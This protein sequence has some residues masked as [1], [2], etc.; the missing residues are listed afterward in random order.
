MFLQYNTNG[1][2]MIRAQQ[3]EGSQHHHEEAH[4]MLAALKRV[5]R[6]GNNQ[7]KVPKNP[8]QELNFCH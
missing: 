6:A 1:I 2:N 8:L 5:Q 4:K 7:K 3:Y